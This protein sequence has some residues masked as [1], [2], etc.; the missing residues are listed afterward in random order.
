VI[1]VGAR[2]GA[3]PEVIG[4][5]GLT[6]AEGDVEELQTQLQRLIDDVDL[7]RDLR[8]KGRQHVTE[9]YTQ[10]AIAHNT[11]TIYREL[12]GD[13]APGTADVLEIKPAISQSA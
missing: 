6:F 7:R 2:S 11:V 13:I 5:A 3:I 12:L 1:T 8:Q 4:Q 9:N 10:A